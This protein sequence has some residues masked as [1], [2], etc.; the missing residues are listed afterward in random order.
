MLPPT[1]MN[2]PDDVAIRLATVD[3]AA[4]IAAVLQD[5]FARYEALYTPEAY[6]ATTPTAEHIQRRWPDGPVW[7]ATRDN[8]VTGTVGAVARG[9]GLYVRSM[10]V[11]S[12]GRGLGLGRL[13]LEAVERFAQ[14]QAIK[15]LYL[16][17]T[18]F[19]A[20]AIRLYEQFG[21]ARTSDGPHELHGTPLFT[22]E[23][24][25]SAVA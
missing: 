7:D 19:L 13:L 17:T 4:A 24:W 20:H 1:P 22:M 11:R 10:A 21:F 12:P 15:R 5:A 9:S 18:P 25:L 16:S 2:R 14:E 3:E 8:V 23:K 6:A